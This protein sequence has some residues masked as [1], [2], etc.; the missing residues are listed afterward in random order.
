M[1]NRTSV[2]R[3]LLVLLFVM[4]VSVFADEPWVELFDGKTLDGWQQKGGQAKYS[5]EDGQIVGKTV[6]NT[7]NSFLCSK[8]FYSDFILEVEFKVD[9]KL[10]SGIQI[11][12][13]SFPEIMNGRVHGY[14]VEIDLSERAYS[15][16]I[17]DEARRGWL[18]DLKDNPSARKAFKQN[19]WNQYRIEAIGDTIKTWIN[20]VPAVNLCDTRTATGF[21]ALQVHSVGKRKEK[22]GIEVRWRNIR[23]ID[24]AV[25]AY[26]TPSPLPV[27]NNDNTLSSREKAFKL[28]FDGK[29]TKGWRGAKLDGFPKTGWSVKD[30]VLTV[31]ESGG[32]ESEAGGDIVT[33]SATVIAAM[34][35]GKQSARAIDEYLRRGAS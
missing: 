23:I 34:G 1:K 30:G 27:K 31:H 9:P 5:V 26:A 24:E 29:T 3:L 14:Q 22:E 18:H 12:S 33:G 32:G 2:N 4:T 7:P 19:Q 20:G 15:A 21:I 10:N 8:Q 11:R 28:L 25:A 6:L 17:F 16:G 13:N 35:A